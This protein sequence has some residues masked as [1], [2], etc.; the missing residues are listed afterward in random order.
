MPV[1]ITP[2]LVCLGICTIICLV[3]ALYL[4]DYRTGDQKHLTTIYSLFYAVGF[5]VVLL[6]ER[7]II[8]VATPKT[9]SIW[10]AEIPVL[11]VTAYVLCFTGQKFYFRP[12]ENMQWFGYVRSTRETATSGH[13]LFPNDRI[14]F[15]R[16]RGLIEVQ[17]SVPGN[18]QTDLRLAGGT[19]EHYVEIPHDLM[20]NGKQIHATLF[21]KTTD[22]NLQPLLDSIDKTL[23]GKY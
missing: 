8:H 7:I 22:W 14:I 2:F 18:R 13:Y 10:A 16:E 9:S 15:I 3:Q 23:P 19:W 5:I 20:I 6:V 17:C 4:Y 1:K 11:L 12:D 21:L